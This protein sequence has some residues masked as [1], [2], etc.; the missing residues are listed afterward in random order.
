MEIL[1]ATDGPITPV[2]SG[3]YS[4]S[5]CRSPLSTAPVGAR[6]H[7]ARARRRRRAMMD[8]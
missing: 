8:A 6:P 1:T 3:I 7:D 5:R 4:R 2:T